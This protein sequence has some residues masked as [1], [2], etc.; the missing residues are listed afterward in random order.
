MMFVVPSTLKPGPMSHPLRGPIRRSPTPSRLV[1]VLVFASILSGCHLLPKDGPGYRHVDEQAQ[2]AE[3][4][5]LP[6]VLVDINGHV[7]TTQRTRLRASIAERFPRETGAPDFRISRG[8]ALTVSIWEAG[9]ETLF[10]GSQTRSTDG[11]APPSARGVQIPAQVVGADGRISIPFAGRIDVVG[12]SP[13][14]VQDSIEKALAGK[15]ARPQALVNV[16]HGGSNMVTVIGEL[17]SGARVPLSM[18]G[19]RLLD[20]I[21]AAGGVRAAAWDTAISLTRGDA[22]VTVPMTEVLRNPSENIYLQ[23]G[24][25]VVVTKRGKTFSAMGATGRTAQVPF[26]S[27]S[28][29]L[30]E[31]VAKAG[32]LLDMRADPRGVYLFRYETMDVAHKLGILD[33]DPRSTPNAQIP[34][35]YRLDMSQAGSFFLA[36]EFEMRDRDILYVASASTN[37]VMKFLNLLGAVTQPVIQ[38]LIIDRTLEK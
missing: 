29:T 8:D 25:S 32:G 21:A 16:A 20:V 17:T 26:E 19:D 31:A 15:A 23:P 22:T 33:E 4:S 38:T 36:Q 28:V 6:F 2:D 3:P 27:A 5:R 11:A 24:D 1:G 7:L 13:V 12:M 30:I 37:Q 34:I 14:D 35:I 10:S 18:N 9:T